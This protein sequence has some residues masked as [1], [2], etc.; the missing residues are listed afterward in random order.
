MNVEAEK[1]EKTVGQVALA[2]W[3]GLEHDHGGRAELRRCARAAEAV[4]CPQTHRLGRA[5]KENGVPVAASVFP[6]M[7]IALSHVREHAAGTSLVA[8]MIGP[9]AKHPVLSTMRFR[10]LLGAASRADMV[11][12]IVRL[13]RMLGGH[14]NVP[15]L[16]E[17]V[18]YWGDEVK[19]RWAFA[20]YE[21]VKQSS[22]E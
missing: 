17:A 1:Q 12:L 9:D 7:A 2:W 20:Y 18:H 16:A 8:A 4:F 11:A 10:R 6:W 19:R 22:K 3:S 21:K 15:E 13:T 14:V 5:L